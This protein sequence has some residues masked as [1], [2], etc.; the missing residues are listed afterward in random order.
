MLQSFLPRHWTATRNFKSHGVSLCPQDHLFERSEAEE[1]DRPDFPRHFPKSGDNS[2]RRKT[3][4][5]TFEKT[6]L[7][8]GPLTSVE[9]NTYSSNREDKDVV[10][11]SWRNK[12][13]GTRK[14]HEDTENYWTRQY[15]AQKLGCGVSK[16]KKV[17]I[18]NK[19][20]PKLQGAHRNGRTSEIQPT[21]RITSRCLLTFA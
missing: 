4:S 7:T 9:M 13:V 17:Q 11:E 16:K 19:N 20:T 3:Q 8:T 18:E 1:S 14:T 6:H 15:S 21:T 5:L 12:E 2:K 10:D